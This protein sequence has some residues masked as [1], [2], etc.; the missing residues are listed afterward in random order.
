M[1]D[2]YESIFSNIK[3]INHKKIKDFDIKNILNLIKILYKNNYFSL[4]EKSNQLDQIRSNRIT[5]ILNYFNSL[6]IKIESNKDIYIIINLGDYNL[7]NFDI[8]L[9]SFNKVINTNNILLFN[10]YFLLHNKI[11]GILNNIKNIDIPFE[12]KENKLFFIGANSNK[13]RYELCNKY[14]NNK[15][16]FFK[17]TNKIDKNS[18]LYENHILIK[19]QLKYKYQICIDGFGTAF[20]RFPWQLLSNSLV[21]KIK[22]NKNLIEWYYP[23][24]EDCYI[25]CDLNDILNIKDY[26]DKNIEKI[27]EINNNS[28]NFV[29][30]FLNKD[31][32][33]TYTK[34]ILEHYINIYLKSDII[35]DKEK[36]KCEC[37]V[38]NHNYLKISSMDNHCKSGIMNQILQKKVIYN[39]TNYGILAQKNLFKILQQN[40]KIDFDIEF[41]GQENIVSENNSNILIIVQ[42]E[43]HMGINDYEVLRRL[44]LYKKIIYLGNMYDEK[45]ENFEIINYKHFWIP[46]IG[47]VFTEMNSYKPDDILGLKYDNYQSRKFCCYMASREVYIRN[48]IWDNICEFCLNN[49]LGDVDSYGKCNGHKN[50]G[51]KLQYNYLN[52]DFKNNLRYDNNV[53]LYKKYKF[54]FVSENC[55]NNHGYITEKIILAFLSGAIPIYYGSEQIFEIFNKESFLYINKNLDNIDSVLNTIKLLN[56]D[57]NLYLLFKSKLIITE[58]SID[59]FF[60]FKDLFNYINNMKYKSI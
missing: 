6:N 21:L 4:F 29:E 60:K 55:Y 22:S 42:A 11:F 35:V 16:T 13:L 36:F 14:K 34:K 20:D 43:R 46:Y 18:K 3:N 38:S 57:I 31:F 48:L 44:N 9:F 10:S 52:K 41:Y 47:L 26:Y 51:N 58:K 40:C 54:V 33:N 17:L 8:P 53:E 15:E 30:K 25:S 2:I 50:L 32:M 49:N 37:V 56:N 5:L 1:I 59:K 28:K 7:F 12:K 24:I 23:F 19:D 27:K 39:K 45:N